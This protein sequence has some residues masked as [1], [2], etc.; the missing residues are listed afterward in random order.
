MT[1]ID[2]AL[3]YTPAQAARNLGGAASTWRKRAAS[4]PG[5][6]QM[7][8]NRGWFMPIAAC[9]AF[10]ARPMGRP[11]DPK[12]SAGAVYRREYRRRNSTRE[13]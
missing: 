11:R 2:P 5:A 13:E 3:Y 9:R 1:T 7:G 8:D 4:I 6:V 12:P 10:V